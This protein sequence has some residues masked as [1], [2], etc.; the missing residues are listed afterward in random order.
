MGISAAGI[1][2]GLDVGS[3]VNQLMV[4]ESAPL[5]RIISK[6]SANN[7]KISA[8]GQLKSA[9]STFQSSLKGL[10]ESGLS[11]RTATSGNTALLDI[12]AGST[13]AP[14]S[15]TVQVEALAKA[16][17]V[18]FKG[19]AST[20]TNLGSGTMSIK[21]GDK[22][23]VS[24]KDGDY[25]LDGLVTAINAAN[26]GVTATIINDG[27]SSPNR[28]VITANDTGAANTIAITASGGLTQFASSFPSGTDGDPPVPNLDMETLQSARNAK[29]KINNI[30]I[31]K[32]SNTIT[33]AVAGVTL[34]LAKEEPG[35]TVNVT[36]AHDKSAV[37]KAITDFVNGY[38]ALN[39]AVTNMTAY[40]ATTKTAGA[41]NGDSAASSIMTNLRAE[42]IK[43][44][45]GDDLATLNNIGVTFQRDGKLAID[46]SKLATALDTKFGELAALFSAEDGYATRLNKVADEMLGS[47]GLIAS[48]TEGLE[49]TKKAL[50]KDQEAMN[51]RLTATEKRIR[52]QFT[53]LD[54]MLAS[55]QSTS[56][57]LT[58][59]LSA[60][61]NNN[62]Y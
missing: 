43:K 61:A 28:L 17:A 25:T 3:L 55:M 11:A 2:S 6:V 56:S 58:Q 38:N 13:A 47:K 4:A 46:D 41:L 44:T 52:A 34:K 48:R 12:S 5:N 54:Q 26:A 9:I 59:Q 49:S 18:A 31:E 39:T 57:Y 50:T 30:S 8:Y 16:H 62:S 33:D 27:S 7:A 53:A 37:K 24:I 51:S 42:L 20:T 35:T 60:I 15:Y 22:D 1:G 36:V 32:P 45:S 19:L 29:I 10:S 21:I 40:N 23:A 14:G